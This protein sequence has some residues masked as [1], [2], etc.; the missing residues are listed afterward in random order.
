MK[1]PWDV[2]EF[3]RSNATAYLQRFN[4]TAI[5]CE[6]TGTAKLNTFSAYCIISIIF[7]VEYLAGYE[8]GDRDIFA[9][10]LKKYYFDCGLPQN[11]Y[12]I[13]Y[14]RSLAEH[15]R[16]KG[17]KDL[18]AYA[19]Q[20]KKIARLLIREGKLS[21]YGAC[22]EFYGG[23][24]EVAQED[25]QRHLNIDWT[26]AGALNVDNIIQEVIDHEDSMLGRQRFLNS[27]HF[28]PSHSAWAPEPETDVVPPQEICSAP[29]PEEKSQQINR[30]T[31]LMDQISLFRLE[32]DTSMRNCIT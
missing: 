26:N 12:Q 15:Q 21:G 11:E 14:F 13:P 9:G 30:L 29:A 6:L 28:A 4:L 18:E 3:N 2:K 24:P 32:M 19:I 25:I 22:T 23:L 17:A 1:L 27:I 5:H 16:S 7:E 10:S 8:D 31:M 20:F